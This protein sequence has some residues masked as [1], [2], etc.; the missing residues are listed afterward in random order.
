MWCPISRPAGEHQQWVQTLVRLLLP[1]RAQA[2]DRGVIA[3]E[4][5]KGKAIR[6]DWIEDLVWKDIK[7]FVTDPGEVLEK[8]QE[9]MTEELAATPSNEE[10]RQEIERI[11]VLKESERDR[12][13]DAYRRSL[14]DIEELE[15]QVTPGQVR[16]RTD[17]RQLFLPPND[18]YFCL[19]S[20]CW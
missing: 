9:R 2:G 12:V 5:C 18:N 6:A 17:Q 4:R 7:A 11:L 15:E 20:S 13:L 16:D 10:R 14:I 3:A 19:F 8:L 1:L